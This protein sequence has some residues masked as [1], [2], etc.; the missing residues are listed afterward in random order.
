MLPSDCHMCEQLAQVHDM[1]AINWSVLPCHVATLVVLD[2]YCFVQELTSCAWTTREK[3]IKAP[4]VV[5]FT[6]RF[7]HVCS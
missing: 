1:V 6:R 3:L 4:N 5:A 2:L 7:N